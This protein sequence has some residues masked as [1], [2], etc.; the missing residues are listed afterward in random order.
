MA[1]VG[2]ALLHERFDLIV[3]VDVMEHIP[4]DVAAFGWLADHL[5]PGG[6]LVMHVPAS[7]QRHLLRSID[8]AI[9]AEVEAGE[10]P[11]V[12]EGYGAD[13]ALALLR[14]AGLQPRSVSFT[15]HGWALRL[16]EDL[17]TVIHRRGLRS[18]KAIV[19]PMLLLAS[20]SERRPAA[21]APGYGL[22]VV[23]DAHA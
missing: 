9:T 22:I 15:F 19:L 12:R 23:A 1:L 2:G 8:R 20:Y 14:A 18:L 11:H 17:D 3:C 21:T 16:A 7:P 4:D 6:A 10:G 5:E 13:E